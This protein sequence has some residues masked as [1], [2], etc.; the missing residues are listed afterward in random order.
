[1]S[2]RAKCADFRPVSFVRAIDHAGSNTAR[3]QICQDPIAVRQQPCIVQMFVRIVQGELGRTG[4][5]LFEPLKR[6]L[7]LLRRATCLSGR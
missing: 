2:R 1:M 6:V 3:C 4:G 7:Q 5:W